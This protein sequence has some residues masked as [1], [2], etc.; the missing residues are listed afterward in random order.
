MEKKSYPHLRSAAYCGALLF[1]LLG[2]PMTVLTFLDGDN[3]R[4]TLEFLTFIYFVNAIFT[5]AVG[6]SRGTRPTSVDYAKTLPITM[7]SEKGTGKEL[8]RALDVLY[9]AETDL[10]ACAT[11]AG[12]FFFIVSL[13]LVAVLQV[14]QG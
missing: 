4:S 10:Y 8:R 11:M 7:M 1:L 12:L 5:G 6:L 2:V 14:W 3:L 9:L 13:V